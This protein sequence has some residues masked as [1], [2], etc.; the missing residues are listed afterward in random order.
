MLELFMRRNFLIIPSISKDIKIAENGIVITEQRPRKCSIREQKQSSLYQTEAAELIKEASEW[1]SCTMHQS[2]FSEKRR[3]S[4]IQRYKFKEEKRF[5]APSQWS[6]KKS[7]EYQDAV[8]SVKA[9]CTHLLHSST[10]VA[11]EG[12]PIQHMCIHVAHWTL[13][14]SPSNELT[15]LTSAFVRTIKRTTDLRYNL[16]WSFGSFL[17]DLPRRLGVDEALDRAVDALTTGHADFCVSQA[18][19]IV[20]MSKYSHALRSLRICLD[21][22]VHAQSSNTLAAGMIL[23]VC[24]MF[25]GQTNQCWSGHAEGASLILKARRHFGP[26][27]QFETKLFLS[28]RGSVVSHCSSSLHTY[29]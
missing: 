19:S 7:A 16:W 18:P 8:G 14:A 23:L 26:R 6:P 27:D 10:A 17:E 2:Y 4:G 11:L 29:I 20:T 1:S 22:P 21:D 3:G 15:A 25:M 5:S 24:Q 13:C 9:R 28:L 12:R